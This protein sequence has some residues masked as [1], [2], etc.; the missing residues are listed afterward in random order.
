MN[1]RRIITGSRDVLTYTYADTMQPLRQIESPIEPV[2][3]S[4]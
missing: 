2:G 4:A 3:Q 1:R